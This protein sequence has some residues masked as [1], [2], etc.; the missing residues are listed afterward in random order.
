MSI[1]FAYFQAI[2]TIR[3]TRIMALAVILIAIAAPVRAQPAVAAGP[4][5]GSLTSLVQTLQSPQQRQELIT[6]L[7]VLIAARD[8]HASPQSPAPHGLGANLVAV[9]SKQA[10]N[11]GTAVTTLAHMTPRANV[12]AWL[13]AFE[14][15]PQLRR[16]WL[17][18][19][20]SSA[21]ILTAAWLALLTLGALLKPLRR[22]VKGLTVGTT[23]ARTL[24]AALAIC[25]GC[26][27]ALV[28]LAVGYAALAIG[29]AAGDVPGPAGVL[30]LAAVNAMATVRVIAAISNAILLP[31]EAGVRFLAV[32]ES[33]ADYALVWISRLSGFTVYGL[34]VL[35]AALDCGLNQAVYNGLLKAFA[36]ALA[37]LL[38]MLILQNRAAVA[39]IILS[40]T[41]ARE[42]SLARLRSR[43]AESW[44]IAAI[45]Y[46]FGAY[47]VWA[48]GNPG[49]FM[50]LL[51]A[52][53][54]SLVILAVAGL[55]DNAGS[56]VMT[57]FLT[58]S[59]ELEQ[60]LPGLQQR[61]NRYMPLLTGAGRLVLYTLA[62]LLVLQAWGLSG[63][64]WFETAPGQHVIGGTVTIAIMAAFAA[65]L[66][67]VVTM[68]A[69]FYVT[70]PGLDGAPVER[71]GRTLTLLPLFRKTLAILLGTAFTLIALATVGVN[72][73]PLLAGAGI[74]GIAVGFG[75]QSLVKD[76][77]TGIFILMQDA[78]SVGD[79]VT[80][81][82]NS[83]RVEQVSIRSIRLRN[84]S[85]T[86]I[87][88]PFSEV[89]TVQNMTKDFAYALFDIGV[90]YREDIDQVID[91]ITDL[92]GELQ[93]DLEYAWRILEPIEILGL[94]QFADSAVIVKARIKTKPIEQWTVMRQFNRRM[95]RR[96]DELGIEIPFPHQ[97]IYFGEDRKG[98]APPANVRLARV[99]AGSGPAESAH[100]TV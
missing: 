100:E 14:T 16:S 75:A 5:T 10:T 57:R 32:G 29:Q 39:R 48:T 62:G 81:A 37:G 63:L 82:G 73:A 92:A 4:S 78:V 25:L 24:G 38:T 79:V 80:V 66:W 9:L 97:T 31:G 11:V 72:I 77:I 74:A 76:V 96:F 64:K 50:F 41:V 40:P 3:A 98:H 23:L 70:R 12:T 67:E 21:S 17:V 36:L 15:D 93:T 22:R 33:A 49:G 69:G 91:V 27:P 89:T 18:G 1:F 71:S 42:G 58:I 99:Q 2:T 34:A 19:V 65:G 28:M 30:A 13:K 56:R 95:K 60:R 43:L 46:L 47:G 61:A 20:A 7:R 55:A 94:D 6:E 52:S 90:A 83:G 45:L 68:A 88:I 8:A 86:V 54:L 51:R 53:A 59:P 87:I 35:S 44:H 85:G 84:L 26:L